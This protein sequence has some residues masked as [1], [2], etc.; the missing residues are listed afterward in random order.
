M[1]DIGSNNFEAGRHDERMDKDKMKTADKSERHQAGHTSG[2]GHLAVR[3][4][5]LCSIL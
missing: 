3:V 1:V 2:C 4:V 5:Q